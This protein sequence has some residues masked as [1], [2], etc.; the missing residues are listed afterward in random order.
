MLSR[1]DRI[2]L[3]VPDR[4]AAAKGWTALLGA[5]PA[6][7]DTV[8][9]LG[10]KRTSLRLG[11]G[12]IELVEPDGPGVVADALAKRGAHLF[13]AGIATKDLD[14]LLKVLNDKGVHPALEHGQAFLDPGRTGIAGLRMVISPDEDLAPVGDVDFLYEVTLLIDKAEGVTEQMATLFNLGA[15]AFVPITSD[16][17]GYTG[18]LTLFEAGKLGRFEIITPN[19]PDNTMGRFFARCG[20]SYYMSFTESGRLPEIEARAKA[21]GAGFTTV[22]PAAERG[23]AAI[24]TVFLHPGSL[25]G[26]MLG[27]SRRTQAWSWSGSPERVEPAK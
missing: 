13:S 16:H 25:G 27:I 15:D 14:G 22:P 9:S 21:L 7:E 2:Q 8:Q 11:T 4:A 1:V 24:D 3:A 18:V 10:A 20:P 17:Y 6:G 19:K 5:E 26:M 23:D 12:W